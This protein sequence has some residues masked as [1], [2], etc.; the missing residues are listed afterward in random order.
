MVNPS[1]AES[2]EIAGVIPDYL[3][4]FDRK[5]FLRLIVRRTQ[6]AALASSLRYPYF[7]LNPVIGGDPLGS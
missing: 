6:G 4:G 5:A 3:A 7:H 1:S 2:T